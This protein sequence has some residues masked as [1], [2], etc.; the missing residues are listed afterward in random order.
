MSQPAAQGGDLANP[1]GTTDGGGVRE[2]TP[3]RM[4][5][6]DTRRPTDDDLYD[7]SPKTDEQRALDAQKET[8]AE[9]EGDESPDPKDSSAPASVIAA[10]Y[11]RNKTPLRR[12]P[13]SDSSETPETPAP[14]DKD[15]T[16]PKAPE[17]GT[18][19]S[20]SKTKAGESKPPA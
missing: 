3:I 5:G 11:E 1:S 8:E 20:P 18:P 12:Q 9:G 16:P 17:S 2:V 6:K 19:S 13:E 10:Y 7:F 15:S 14:A 4:W